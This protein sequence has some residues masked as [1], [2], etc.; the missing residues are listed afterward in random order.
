MESEEA[1]QRNY[2]SFDR[3]LM[4]AEEENEPEQ[5]PFSQF[6]RKH[7]LLPIR[8]ML[9]LENRKLSEEDTAKAKLLLSVATTKVLLRLSLETFLREFQKVVGKLGR[10]LKKRKVEVRENARSCLCEIAK[11][12]GP[13]LLSSIIMALKSSLQDNF[14]GHVFNYT[15]YKVLDGMKLQA[16]DLDYCIPLFL[17]MV[18]D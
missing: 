10:L 18:I 5:D 6:L 14:E 7:I 3:K 16:G 13:Q 12:V 4:E 9:L 2:M 1:I 11:A 15:A 8:T 17:P